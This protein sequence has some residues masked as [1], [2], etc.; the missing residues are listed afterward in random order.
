MTTSGTYAFS[1]PQSVELIEDAF[2]RIGIPSSLLEGQK[3]NAAKR[4]LNFIL[5]DLVNKGLNLWTVQQFMLNLVPNQASYTMPPNTIRVLEATIRQSQRNLG[6]TPFTSAGGNAANAFDNN[7]ATACTQTAPNGYISYNWNT[8]SYT[9]AL[10]GVQSNATLTYTLVFE[11]SNDNVNWFQVG[12]APAQTYTV[13]LITW[14]VVTTPTNGALFR[15]R[16]TG[17]STLNVQELFFNTALTDWIIT[18]LSRSEYVSL[19]YKNQTGRPT[20]FYLDRQIVPILNVWPVPTPQYNNLYFTATQAIQD[21]GQ[22]TN[23]PQVPA[24]FL[25]S[26]TAIL[27][28]NLA[29]KYSLPMD[30]IQM[31]KA[32]A[33]QVMSAASKSDIEKVPL[34]IYGNY[35]GWSDV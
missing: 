8:A 24:R 26:I 21:I 31:L 19:Q 23:N 15:V 30:K 14:F 34:R 13:G 10:V 12:S 20:S 9:I 5:S 29:V 1:S 2:E 25:E 17:G 35:Q 33:D 32:L 7:P 16:E 3:I 4:S 27:A 6:G 18:P 22:L 28:Y 11:Y